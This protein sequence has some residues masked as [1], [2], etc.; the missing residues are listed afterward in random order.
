MQ[1]K[2][3]PMLAG[4]IALAVTTIPLPV[5]AETHSNASLLVAQAQEKGPFQRLGLTDEQKDQMAE[6]R[7]NTRT[8]IEAVL[9]PEQKEQ[10]QTA[11]ENSRGVRGA[12]KSMNLTPEQRSQV[13]QIMQSSKEQMNA[14]LTPE[15]RQQ[16][17]EFRESKRQ[18]RQQSDR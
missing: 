5:K 8:Q 11:M 13:R 12:I 6:I 7:R 15:Q 9:T 17:Q 14:V 2:L 18:Q 16:L 4:V 10:F 1:L 3:M